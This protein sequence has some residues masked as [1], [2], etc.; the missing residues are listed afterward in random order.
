MDTQRANQLTARL[1]TGDQLTASEQQLLLD[2]F[3]QRPDSLEEYLADESTDD[4]LRCL[5]WLDD[6]DDD[7]VR[8]AVRRVAA[9]HSASRLTDPIMRADSAGLDDAAFDPRKT[10]SLASRTKRVATGLAVVAAALVVCLVGRFLWVAWTGSSGPS[11]GFAS[12]ANV[13]EAVWATPRAEGDRLAADTLRLERGVVDVRF[14][15]GTVARLT[16]PAVLQLRNSDEVVLDEG[17]LSVKVPKQAVGFSVLTP[18]GRV[19]DLGTEFDVSVDDAG[20]TETVVRRGKVLFKPQRNGELPG[21]PIE[22]S[23]EGLDRAVSS[24]PDVAAPV[25]PV[26]ITAS[27]RRGRFVGVISANGKTLE[28]KSLQAFREHQSRVIKQLREAPGDFD[29]RWSNIVKTQAK[30]SAGGSNNSVSRSVSVHVNGK[31]VLIT[32]S[33]ESGVSVTIKET[34]DGTEKSVTVT[35]ADAEDLAR[36]NPEAFR[37]YQRHLNRSAVSPK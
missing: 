6:A 31:T 33:S 15:K 21:K 4:L 7:F 34:V 30:A 3:E 8:N 23:S 19:L 5:P 20:K 36:K 17:S 28:F 26:S 35:A 18:V 11:R 32:E 10:P 25:L 1:A 13:E 37:L 24:V 29:R 12:L 27:G 22:L 2:W 16:G 14:D 9:A